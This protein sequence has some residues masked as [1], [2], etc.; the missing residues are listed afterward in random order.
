MRHFFR[1]IFF[2]ISIVILTNCARTGNPEGGPKDE[3][4]PLFV[5]SKPAYETINFDAKEI[6]LNFNE[7]I[8]LKDLNKQLIVSP[9]LKTPLLVTPQSTASKFLNIKI[10]DTLQ[11]NTTYIINF[12]NAIEDNNEGNK[13]ESFKY[14]FSTGKY[15]DSL[16][17]SGKIKDAYLDESQK[18]INVL[19]YKIDSSFT[20]S[21]VFKKKPN[22]VTSSLDTSLFNLTNLKEGKYLMVA[23]KETVNDYLFN[24]R[25]DKIGFFTDT[26]TLPRDSIIKKPIILFK[27]TQPY[28]FKRGKEIT[29]GKIEFGYE[30]VIK[31]L[32]VQIISDT[33]EDFRS[34]SKLEI[35]KDT[36]NYWYKPFEADSLNFIVTN[37]RFID[38]VTVNLRKKKTDSLILSSSVSG[39]LQLRDTFFIKGNNPLVKI[40]TSKITLVDKDTLSVPF[41]SIISNIENKIAFIFDKEPQQKYAF[42]MMPD[43]ISDIFEQKNDT[44][45]FKFTTKEI[46]DYGRIT[47]DIVNE[48][49]NHLIIELLEGKNKDKL[50]ERRF[51]TGSG[52]IRYNLLEPKTYFIRAIIDEN[53]N[54]KWDTGNYLLKQQ[55]ESI[56][57]YPQ[58]L[59]LRA[60]YYLDGNVFT[61]KNPE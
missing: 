43:A 3:D 51:I 48:T 41:V 37:D 21:I 14:V 28:S 33:P 55:P 1:L 27:E 12:G 36:L 9:P 22:Y 50:I 52:Q 32:K 6:E 46:E 57:Y 30:G 20:D 34:V 58:E 44:L 10:L 7:Y 38:T 13:L 53:K 35:D 45:N 5:T 4:A 24:P 60:N 23:L 15:I 18:N 19:L 31:D 39:T 49:S 47:M 2:S 61:V 17:T 11:E 8:K 56:I 59:K 25:E 29:R 40:D 16:S 42:K 54:N 26:I